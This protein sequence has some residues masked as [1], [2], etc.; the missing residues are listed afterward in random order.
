MSPPIVSKMKFA[1]VPF[2]RK[3]PVPAPATPPV[4]TGRLANVPVFTAPPAALLM[5]D[6][7]LPLLTGHHGEVALEARPHGLTSRVSSTSAG[8]TAKLL[9]QTLWMRYRSLGAA[10]AA[11][12]SARPAIATAD[13]TLNPRLTRSTATGPPDSTL[14][15]NDWDYAERGPDVQLRVRTSSL[16]VP[17]S[18]SSSA[19]RRPFMRL[20]T[21]ST[22]SRS[23]TIPKSRW[24]R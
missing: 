4:G 2:T 23:A 6:V 18:S 3:L 11:L 24:S 9:D 8:N 14:D 21:S 7:L 10:F 17:T 1:A 13:V 12:A 22:S 5:V 19:W 16:S 20:H 15:R